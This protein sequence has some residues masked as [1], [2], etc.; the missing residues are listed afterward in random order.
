MCAKSIPSSASFTWRGASRLSRRSVHQKVRQDGRDSFGRSLG[1]LSMPPSP[2]AKTSAVRRMTS[3]MRSLAS[4]LPGESA[5]ATRSASPRILLATSTDFAWRWWPGVGC[6]PWPF[7]ARAP[8]PAASK[9]QKG[10]SRWLLPSRA[11]ARLSP[12]SAGQCASSRWCTNC[13]SAATSGLRIVSANAPSG[14]FFRRTDAA[15]YPLACPVHPPRQRCDWITIPWREP[16]DTQ[17]GTP[18]TITSHWTDARHTPPGC[19]PTS[20]RA[21]VRRAGARGRASAEAIGLPP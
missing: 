17:R 2:H 1:E 6:S 11:S 9:P 10:H 4:G 19:S 15:S 16:P 18:R 20:P 7:N 14:L 12:L 21:A 5:E 13:T 3:S 8:S